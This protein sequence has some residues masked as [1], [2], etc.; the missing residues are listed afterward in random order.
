MA[1]TEETPLLTMRTTTFPL[2]IRTRLEKHLDP[3]RPC[4]TNPILGD[5]NECTF[6][7]YRTGQSD[8]VAY[9]WH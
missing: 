3:V 5:G 1:I 4:Y 6:T 7:D 9:S 2:P 8:T